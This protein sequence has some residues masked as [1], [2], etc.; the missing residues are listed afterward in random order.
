MRTVLDENG[1]VKS[2]FYGKIYGDFT[3]D[4]INSK[5]TL[6][7]FTYYLNPTP[8]DRNVESDPS[9]NLFGNLPA[10]QRVKDP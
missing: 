8:N 3:L 1:R 7:L 9:R 6:I 5:T 10:M 4:P 2:A